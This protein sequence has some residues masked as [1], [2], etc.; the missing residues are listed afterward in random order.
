MSLESANL[1]APYKSVPCRCVLD[2]MDSRRK[3]THYKGPPGTKKNLGLVF[4]L[5]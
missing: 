3:T 2:I 1:E 5:G 4:V